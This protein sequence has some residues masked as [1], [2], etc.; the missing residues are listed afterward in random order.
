MK[1]INYFIV[2]IIL[3][4]NAAAQKKM[5]LLEKTISI[6]LNNIKMDAALNQVA[7]TAGFTFSYNP[8]LIDLSHTVNLTFSNKTIREILQVM[9]NGKIE[10]KIKGNYIIL[11][12]AKIPEPQSRKEEYFKVSG[13]VEK[14]SGE[15]IPWVSIY[16]KKSMSSAVSDEYGFYSIELPI[17]LNDLSLN[18]SK[19]DFRDTIIQLNDNNTKFQNIILE[20]VKA[21]TA[22]PPVNVDSLYNRA[23]ETSHSFFMSPS[24][25]ANTENIKDTIYRPY[26]VSFIPFA[27]TNGRL[28]GNV[29]N[30]YSFNIFGGYS[31]GTRKLEMAGFF[32]VDRDDVKSIQLAGFVNLVGGNVSGCQMAGSVNTVRKNAEGLQAAGFVNLVGGDF[33]GCQLAGFV[34][35]TRGNVDGVQGAGYVNVAWGNTHGAQLAGFVN[36]TRGK[37]NTFQ[38]AGFVNTVIDTGA[39]AQVAG[40]VNYANKEFTGTQVSGFANIVMQDMK[41]SQIG[42]FNYTKNL[43]GT[44]V[45]F[46][47]YSKSCTGIPVGFISYVKDGYHKIDFY[48]D[49]IFYTNVS[50]RTGVK[51]LHN[52]FTAGIRPD[53]NNTPLWTFGYGF[54]S[55]VK[56]GEKV[57]LDFDLTSN[58][59]EKGGHFE[60]INLVNKLYIGFDIHL[61]KKFSL[62]AGPTVNAQITDADYPDY[63]KVFNDIQPHLFYNSN[64]DEERMNVRMW[65]GGKVGFRFL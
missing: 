37:S 29:I 47:N 30:D 31:M 50:F 18:I 15:K 59:V 65:L 23:E 43:K 56:L 51:E 25:I 6:K 48:G 22:Q 38:M 13:Y 4:L 32:N 63:P 64:L 45:G 1:K 10:G 12:K 27:G 55:T 54:G 26:Q 16:N 39:G 33:N 41:G 57:D 19:K 46:F 11:V 58:Q 61:A 62:I 7:A 8:S 53:I 44:Q 49:E 3:S 40:F 5:P 60:K 35:T 42:F 20:P 52:I 2:L 28:S 9:F 14:T 21:D 17:E 34:N 24:D 36:T